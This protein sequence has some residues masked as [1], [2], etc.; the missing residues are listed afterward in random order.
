MGRVKNHYWQEIEADAF[1]DAIGGIMQEISE[2]TTQKVFAMVD[3]AADKCNEAAQQYLY[4]GHG[5][6]TGD[7]RSHFAVARER[8]SKRH[9]R[10]TWHV[11]EPEYRLT[12]LLENGH[13]TR[14]G[15]RRTKPVKHIKH[16]REIAEQVLDEK[17]ANLWS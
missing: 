13:A 8:L 12:H 17:L 15:T 14:D 16:G 4:K 10:A 3:E 5:V 2:E 1:A 7:Y 9:H 11:E 6:K